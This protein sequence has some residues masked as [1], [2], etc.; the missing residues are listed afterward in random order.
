M[1]SR[2]K[3]RNGE[4][5]GVI[6]AEFK[7]QAI[8]EGFILDVLKKYSPDKGDRA[9]AFGNPWRKYE[10]IL[11]TKGVPRRVRCRNPMSKNFNATTQTQTRF[12][13]LQA[14]DAMMWL[15]RSS[16]GSSGLPLGALRR[17]SVKQTIRGIVCSAPPDL[18]RPL[19]RRLVLGADI[20]VAIV[21]RS[22]HC[23]ACA[24]ACH[25]CAP[26]ESPSPPPHLPLPNPDDHP[27][28]SPPPAPTPTPSSVGRSAVAR[29]HIPLPL[30]TFPPG[31]GRSEPC[32]AAP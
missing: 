19:E 9:I 31:F 6:L 23:R 2:Y 5:R 14:G 30:L 22:C 20:A 29:S 13:C 15:I 10:N 11:G 17:S 7:R 32:P 8:A 28:H 26:E 24:P 18:A 21:S 16:R 25:Q 1:D 12:P 3:H 4:E 27:W